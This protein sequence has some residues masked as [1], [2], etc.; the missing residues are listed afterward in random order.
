MSSVLAQL[1]FLLDSQQGYFPPHHECMKQT[2]LSH[3]ETPEPETLGASQL[4]RIWLTPR[5]VAALLVIS[6][7]LLFP[8][9]K[10]P[11][12]P[13]FQHQDIL[14]VATSLQCKGRP[15]DTY[16]P[17]LPGAGEALSR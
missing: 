8:I 10:G 16:G 7:L 17:L 3:T 15:R 4:L 2:Y 11:A 13:G 14:A 9:N 1:P 5:A 12:Q 6:L